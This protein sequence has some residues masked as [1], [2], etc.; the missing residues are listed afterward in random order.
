MRFVL[1]LI[2]GCIIAGMA[3]PA[4]ALEGSLLDDEKVTEAETLKLLDAKD[5]EGRY[6]ALATT[7]AD[8]D[9]DEDILLVDE[10]GNVSIMLNERNGKFAKSAWVAGPVNETAG[11]VSLD[12]SDVDLDN[13]ED[14]LLT[15]SIG[16]VYLVLAEGKGRYRKM[17]QISEALNPE[18]GPVQVRVSDVDLDNDEDVIL[19]NTEGVLYQIE[20]VGMGNFGRAT[21]LTKVPNM[22]P[23]LYDYVFTDLDFDNDEEIIF[24]DG[25]GTVYLLENLRGR[26]ATPEHIAGPFKAD[27]GRVDIEIADYDY[28]GDDDLVIMG[29]SGIVVLLEN[30]GQGDFASELEEIA[31]PLGPEDGM[32]I[33]A[34]SDVDAETSEDIVVLNTKGFLFTIENDGL[35]VYEEPRCIAENLQLSAGLASVVREDMNG[36]GAEDTLILDGEGHLY[37]VLGEYSFVEDRARDLGDDL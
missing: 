24:I 4:F 31:P 20:N 37:L 25:K 14:L 3:C 13:D 16:M 27:A 11:P 23:G 8:Q 35:G 21:E 2:I 26:F 17:E 18:S 9:A 1:S 29:S 28:D 12:L 15:N 36:D 33:M 34:L 22:V 32:K 19:G 10:M 7:D 30:E 5:V 6:V